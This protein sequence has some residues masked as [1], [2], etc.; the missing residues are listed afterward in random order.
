MKSIKIFFAVIFLNLLASQQASAATLVGFWNF[1]ETAATVFDQSGQGNNG[2]TDATRTV[3]RLGQGLQ[4]DGTNGVTI[5]HSASL[6][7]LPGGFTFSAWINPTDYP[8]Y[9]TV[10]WKTDRN[11]RIHMLHFQVGDNGNFP[12]DEGRSYAAMN[13][14]AGSGGFEGISDREVPLDEWSYIAWTYDETIFRYY[15]NGNEI[16]SKPFTQP[17]MGNDV[18]LLIG[19]HPEVS[20]A[21][22]LG[23]IDEARIYRG[24]LTQDEI[25]RDMNAGIVPEPTTLALLGFGLLGFFLNKKKGRKL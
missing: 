24:A 20:S 3:G 8:D 15:I 5:P 18:D 13:K 10:F 19:Y 4:F 9:T 12:V 22:F 6:D 1:E 14:E 2:S 16:F 25:L 23:S 7:S 21:R 11:N 17:W